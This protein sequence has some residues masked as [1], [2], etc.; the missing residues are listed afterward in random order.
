MPGGSAERQ[1]AGD[2]HY[3]LDPPALTSCPYRRRGSHNAHFL[4]PL[5]VA[6]LQ[7]TRDR[8]KTVH[9]NALLILARLGFPVALWHFVV[10]SALLTEPAVLAPQAAQAV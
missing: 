6:A 2:F 5:F 3:T 4:S 8:H 1:T 10:P 9:L 7:Q